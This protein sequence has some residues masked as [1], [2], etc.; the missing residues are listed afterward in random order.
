MRGGAFAIALVW[1]V[2]Q[3]TAEGKQLRVLAPDGHPAAGAEVIVTV[4]SG[5]AVGASLPYRTTAL[6]DERGELPAGMPLVPGAVVVVDHRDFAPLRLMVPDT[7]AFREIRLE[8]GHSLAGLVRKER[9]QASAGDAQVCVTGGM[10]TDLPA[11]EHVWKR[12]QPIGD[13]GKFV[14]SGLGPLPWEVVVR[15]DRCVPIK[16]RIEREEFVSITLRPGVDIGGTVEDARGGPLGG[17]RVLAGEAE[18]V[19]RDD[20]TFHLTVARAPVAVSFAKQGFRTSS[21]DVPEATHDIK[22]RMAMLPTVAATLLTEEGAYSGTVDVWFSPQRDRED[23]V[24]LTSR[25][26]SA[27]GGALVVGL[28]EEGVY[29]ITL[30]PQGYEEVRFG[31]VSVSAADQTHL[32]TAVLARGN[33]LHGAAVDGTTGE[34]VPGAL[35]DLVPVGTTIFSMVLA[36]A[37]LATVSNT[38][39]DFVLG[40]VRAGRYLLRVRHGRYA[41]VYRILNLTAFHDVGRVE[42]G[43]GVLVKGSVLDFGL[44]PRCAMTVKLFDAAREMIEPL[45][46][47]VVDSEGSFAFPP[48]S[49]GQ[50]RLECW[51]ARLLRSEEVSLRT[52]PP[53]HELR[54]DVGGATVSGVVQ[55]HGL[56]VGGGRIQLASGLARGVAGPR[57]TVNLPG[58]RIEVGVP[59]EAP[60]AVVNPDGTFALDDAPTGSAWT[61]FTNGRSFTVFP[62]RVPKEREVQLVVSLPPGFL[63][64]R[65]TDPDTRAGLPGSVMLVDGA[66]GRVMGWTSAANDGSFSLDYL[67]PGSY[68]VVA[69][70]PGYRPAVLPV[71]VSQGEERPVSIALTPGKKGTI[72]VV[73]HRRDTEPVVSVPVSIFARDGRF[74]AGGLTQADGSPIGFPLL[75]PGDYFVAWGDPL[76][77]ADAEG[78]VHLESGDTLELRPPV[79]ERGTSLA[80]VC[81][82]LQC[83]GERVESLEVRNPNGFDLVPLLSG[84]TPEIR[85]GQ[86]GVVSL[87][88]IATGR[89]TVRLRVRGHDYST[90]VVA[91]DDRTDAVF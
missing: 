26:V 37:A 39:G 86:D 17:V 32:G 6:T 30:R 56:P 2:A 8:D 61:T 52:S 64:G 7:A 50:Y 68:E 87:G 66:Q 70:A 4:S 46:E 49:P 21:V 18:T 41:P 60:S 40:G 81:P 23:R 54:M 55:A 48:L 16:R 67:Q 43:D 90:S 5:G 31:S 20:G 27:T 80:V 36:Q 63:R 53:V 14:L 3:P 29:A 82:L 59:M 73:L 51:G 42:L 28:P 10:G 9:G 12:C 76:G 89:L 35:V 72:R 45:A 69:G 74:V 78:P 71:T 24:R 75:P 91:T 85:F 38:D 83:D 19:T 33:G 84:A 88:R 11:G 58:G 77:G 15:A 34:P 25:Q 57:L 1:S 62:L 65:L 13:D 44:P 47:A 79:G 22:V